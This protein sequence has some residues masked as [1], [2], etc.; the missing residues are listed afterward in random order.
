VLFP[1]P[2]I[3]KAGNPARAKQTVDIPSP[4]GWLTLDANRGEEQI[5]AI[6]SKQALADPKS[7]A[8]GQWSAIGSGPSRGMA[9]APRPGHHT[10]PGE[11]V[12]FDRFRFLH[13]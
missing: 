12:S 10:G 3:S 2:D 7:L 13:R 9:A 5:V 4:D 6:A 1:N 8:F 11:D